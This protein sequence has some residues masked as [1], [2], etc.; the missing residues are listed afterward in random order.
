MVEVVAQPVNK[1][2]AVTIIAVTRSIVFMVP[3]SCTRI[4][5]KAG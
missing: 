2:A 3:N 1:P 4:L 5:V